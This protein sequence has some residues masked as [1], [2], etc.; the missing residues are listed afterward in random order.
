MKKFQNRTPQQDPLKPQD[1]PGQTNPKLPDIEDPR[2]PNNPEQPKNPDK[3]CIQPN[4]NP[5]PKP[6]IIM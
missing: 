6:P 1:D 3:P 5:R 4:P 2:Q